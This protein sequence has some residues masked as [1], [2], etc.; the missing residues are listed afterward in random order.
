MVN[1]FVYFYEFPIVSIV[2]LL[3]CVVI[4]VVVLMIILLLLLL[5]CYDFVL[6]TNI[7]KCFLTFKI[8]INDSAKFLD[9]CV[10]VVAVVYGRC[11]LMKLSNLCCLLKLLNDVAY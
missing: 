10:V 3:C 11:L 4:V 2:L 8:V 6:M 5:F 7:L 9:Q 1:S